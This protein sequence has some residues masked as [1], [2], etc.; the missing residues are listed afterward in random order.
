MWVLFFGSFIFY[1]L[2]EPRWCLVLLG[3]T[4]FNYILGKWTSLQRKS[5]L[6]LAVSFDA[7][8]L[9]LFKILGSTISI[10]FLPI[11]I[12]FYTFKMI[13]YQADLYTGKL[14]E[15]P[16]FVTTA[17]YFYFFPQLLQGPIMRPDKMY[18]SAIWIDSDVST[19]KERIGIYLN[20]IED[21]LK[22]FIAG[23]AMKVLI[24]DHLAVL[25]KDLH[26]IGYESISTP[27]AWIGALAYSLDLY[28]DFWGY[29]LMAAGFGVALGFP[30][31]KNFNHPYAALGVRDFY[32]RWHMS[33]GT[34][35]RDYIYIP[36]GGNRRGDFR[37]ILNLLLVWLL[38]GI[39]HGITP[40]YIIWGMF[41]YVLILSEKYIISVNKT[42]FNVVSRLNVFL[43]IP[44]SW[45]IFAISDMER[46]TVYMTRLFPFFGISGYVNTSDYIKYSTLYWP[47]IV[48]GLVLLIPRVFDFCEKKRKHPVAVV[49]L[50][51]LFWLCIFSIAN[52]AGNPLMYLRF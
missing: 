38:T 1:T 8:L 3:A 51:V 28:F 31:V 25:W 45:V 15:R 6:I 22:Y 35:F 49:V 52:T 29:S 4:I 44:I 37:G 36:L 27:L 5:F 30:F 41:L 42:L 13:A 12:S 24:A 32:R 39:W 18:S 50:F 19:R 40:N 46:L 34:W 20:N 43:M 48:P 26:T 16:D 21:G 10:D 9:M 47:Y 2:G 33:L 14:K 17:S 7:G 11:G 23:M